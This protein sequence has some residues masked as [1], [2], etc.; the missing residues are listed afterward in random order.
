MAWPLGRDEKWA[1]A[2][3]D[4]SK[5]KVACPLGRDEKCNILELNLLRENP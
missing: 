2:S 3:K 4:Y 5:N 1:T